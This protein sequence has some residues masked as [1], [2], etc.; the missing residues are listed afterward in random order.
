MLLRICGVRSS[1]QSGQQRYRHIPGTR[2]EY[3]VLTR[4]HAK[5]SLYTTSVASLDPEQ[6]GSR[7]QLSC[8]GAQKLTPDL[9]I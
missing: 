1:Q 4:T 7:G 5:S 9:I 2:I 3:L 8:P 6:I